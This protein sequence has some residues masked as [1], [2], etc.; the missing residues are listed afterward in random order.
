MGEILLSEP[1]P[2]THD[3]KW[4]CCAKPS[5]SVNDY[6]PS[7]FA[8]FVPHHH[9]GFQGI[10]THLHSLRLLLTD[11]SANAPGIWGDTMFGSVAL[12]KE[13]CC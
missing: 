3:P 2:S 4:L 11:F 7:L 10:Y 8:G 9:N 13:L 12:E 1:S 5:V 6:N